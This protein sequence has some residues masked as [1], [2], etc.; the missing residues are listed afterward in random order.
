MRKILLL[1]I[2]ILL[3][4][5]VFA[6]ENH[7]LLIKIDVKS[8][9]NPILTK[10]QNGNETI[11]DTLKIN[12]NAIYFNF[13]NEDYTGIY[14]IYFSSKNYLNFIYNYEDIEFKTSFGNLY[15]SLQVINSVENKVYFKYLKKKSNFE[16]K[17]RAVYQ[18]LNIYAKQDAFYDEVVEEIKRLDLVFTEYI[19][20]VNKQY[21]GT[22][23][24]KIVNFEHRPS[25]NLKN[26]F[27]EQIQSLKDHFFNLSDFKDPVLLNTPFF[28]QKI[29]SYL[30]LFKNPL[31]NN[32]QQNDEFKKAVKSILTMAEANEKI[33]TFTLDVLFKEFLRTNNEELQLYLA[34]NNSLENVCVNLETYEELLEKMSGIQRV[35][36]NNFSPDFTINDIYEKEINLYKLNYDYTLIVFWATWCPHCTELLPKLK[37]IY[38]NQLEKKLEIIAVS[39][40]QDKN[41]FTN[42]IIKGQYNWINYTSFEGWDDA[43]TKLYAVYATPT[44]FL[45]DNNKKIIAKPLTIEKLMES[46]Q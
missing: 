25:I 37:D 39:L 42:E 6:T 30:K 3:S 28:Q 11:I 32:E 15:D 26:N 5:S 35:A 33:Y 14:R 20:E 40:D 2:N 17:Q 24:S 8:P 4:F 36:V 34:Q 38:D 46:F 43:L 16:N 10:F 21:P 9:L 13:T 1:T 23:V 19:L 31:L 12:D 41:Q 18:C 7:F 27:D 45:L 22:L 29:L 44:M